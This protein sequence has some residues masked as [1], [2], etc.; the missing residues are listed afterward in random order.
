MENSPLNKLSAELRN[1]IAEMALHC[2]GGVTTNGKDNSKFRYASAL[3]HTCKQMR[4]DYGTLFFNI[5]NFTHH[6]KLD[7]FTV[8]LDKF[9]QIIGPVNSMAISPVIVS[10]AVNQHTKVSGC[11]FERKSTTSIHDSIE[12]LSEY[13]NSWWGTRISALQLRLETY[14]SSGGVFRECRIRQND[15]WGSLQEAKE[16]VKKDMDLDRRLAGLGP[17]PYMSRNPPSQLGLYSIYCTLE[18]AEEMHTTSK[19]RAEEYEKNERACKKWEY[20]QAAGTS[21]PKEYEEL[22]R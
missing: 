2:E 4:E 16:T 9:Q 8:E 13:G 7:G 21:E 5:N 12:E 10:L 1:T 6:A 22:R 3:A 11:F 20:E 19:A 14:A 18:D 15:P 17:Y